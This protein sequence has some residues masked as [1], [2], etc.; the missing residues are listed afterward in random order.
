[1]IYVFETM[2][3]VVSLEPPLCVP[4]I[5]ALFAEYDERFSLYRPSSELSAIAGGKRL[6]N[7]SDKMKDAYAQALRWRTITG[8][9]FT[10][11]RPDGVIDLSG[12]VKALAMDAAGRLLKN[13]EDWILRAGSKILAS[14]TGA[15]VDI[16]D[17]G[18][19]TA[20]LTS[21]TL[22]GS[23][24][25][26][27]TSG[28]SERGDHFWGRKT[29]AQV[30]VVADDIVTA[31]VLATAIVAGGWDTMNH[32]TGTYDIDVLAIDRQ[33]NVAATP[34]LRPMIAA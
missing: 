1:M 20:L 6:E 18:R 25:A 17:P 19:R 21:V 7:A 32:A 11:Y 9:A 12:I 24:R 14:G 16:T 4:E 26:V 8:G 3:T 23:R 34:G 28:I 33:G 31:D 10:P 29:F 13:R 22:T 27:A 2:G 30:T 15:T 5:E